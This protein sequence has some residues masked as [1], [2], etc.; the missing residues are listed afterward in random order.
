[1][2]AAKR[3]EDSRVREGDFLYLSLSF[4]GLTGYTV[5]HRNHSEYEQEE[6]CAINMSVTQRPKM[7]P[8][9]AS[10]FPNYI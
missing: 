5:L 4:G 2:Q 1:M 8:R 9:V 3:R 7:S 10:A 6:R